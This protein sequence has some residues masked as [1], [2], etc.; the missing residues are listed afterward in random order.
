MPKSRL[1]LSAEPR[2]ADAPGY[3]DLRLDLG[4]LERR[5][6]GEPCVDR[7]CRKMAMT[8]AEVLGTFT[9]GAYRDPATGEVSMNGGYDPRFDEGALELIIWEV[10]RA[11][12]APC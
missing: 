9:P 6:R 4:R 12:V 8:R 5:L 11:E 3:H 2:D 10:V 1:V 7:L